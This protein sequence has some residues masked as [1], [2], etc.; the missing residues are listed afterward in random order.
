MRRTAGMMTGL[1][2]VTRA[3]ALL[4]VLL[5]TGCGSI[6]LFGKYDIPESPEV[7]AAPWPRLVDVPEAL[8]AGSFGPSA[9][10]PA[11]GLATEAALSRASAEARPRAATLSQP[12]ID[13]VTRAR[14]L[15]RAERA[16]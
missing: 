14:M 7:A 16:R 3:A 15:A 6:A 2:G 12:V 13:P 1:N 10:D 4:A 8:P 11:I 5:L 9:P